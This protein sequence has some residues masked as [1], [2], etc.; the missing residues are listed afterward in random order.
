ML[1]GVVLTLSKLA[2]WSTG[3]AIHI[4]YLKYIK[5]QEYVYFVCQQMDCLCTVPNSSAFNSAI[6]R[7]NHN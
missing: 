5:L 7:G 6:R 4:S 3:F 2:T 1:V